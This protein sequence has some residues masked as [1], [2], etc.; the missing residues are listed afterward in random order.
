MPQKPLNGAYEQLSKYLRNHNYFPVPMSYF[1][2]KGAPLSDRTFAVGLYMFDAIEGESDA[3]IAVTD[4]AAD[5]EMD[6]R[7]VSR[8][9]SVL[10]KHGLLEKKGKV[11]SSPYQQTTENEPFVRFSSAWACH[12]RGTGLT[13]SDNRVASLLYAVWHPAKHQFPFL[14]FRHAGKKMLA[15]TRQGAEKKIK[16]S[17]ESWLPVHELGD[18]GDAFSYDLRPFFAMLENS[19]RTGKVSVAPVTQEAQSRSEKKSPYASPPL[20]ADLEDIPSAEETMPSKT[21]HRLIQAPP[22][23]S[24]FKT[25]LLDPFDTPEIRTM[26]EENKKRLSDLGLLAPDPDHGEITLEQ[27]KEYLTREFRTDAKWAFSVFAEKCLTD[28]LPKVTDD[29]FRERHFPDDRRYEISWEFAD[30][31]TPEAL[32]DCWNKDDPDVMFYRL[33]KGHGKHIMRKWLGEHISEQTVQHRLE[34]YCKPLGA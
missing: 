30:S 25:R 27:A 26:M 29:G 34:R 33:T 7:D 8:D 24:A 12:W 14:S 28:Q 2:E 31:I 15:M 32:R 1:H 19:M 22:R 9:V 11:F 6:V 20:E 21:H 13:W 10:I 3:R 23:S 17:V 16:K 5:L 18:E 4:V